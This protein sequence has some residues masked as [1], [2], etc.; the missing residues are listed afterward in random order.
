MS[1]LVTGASGFI[2]HHVARTLLSR[3]EEVVATG[4]TASALQPLQSAGARV[5][6]ADLSKDSL[7]ELTRGCHAVVHCAAMAAP[8]GQRDAFVR[9]NVQS[10]ERLLVAAADAGVK[11]FVHLSSP[12]IYSALEHQT[13]VPEAFTAPA[14][15]PTPYGETKW[16]SEQQVLD[17]CFA[18]MEPVVLRPRAVFGEGD[19]A[20]VPRVLAVAKRGRFPL[21]DGGSALIDVTYVGNVVSAI[22]LALRAPREQCGQAY[23]ITNGEPMTVRDLL[24]RLFAALG[25]KVRYVPL[26]RPVAFGLARLAESFARV[27][28]GGGEPRLTRYGIALLAYSLTLDIRAARE[29]LGYVPAVSVN[30]GLQ[31]YATWW[32]THG[33]H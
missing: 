16:L 5:V 21:I 1:V 9:D 20:I 4:R 33:T 3:G 6:T 18:S 23:N 7:G 32:K 13:N 31:R 26:A 8:W 19:R 12:S 15:W 14:H 2:G 25:L 28:P 17:P 11:R 10:T 30:E 27:R 29:R 22:E 24:D